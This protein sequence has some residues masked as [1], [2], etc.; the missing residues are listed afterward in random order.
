MKQKMLIISLFLVVG[1]V[2]SSLLAITSLSFTKQIK[3]TF[4]DD[5]NELFED[6]IKLPT[7]EKKVQEDKKSNKLVEWLTKPPTGV[8]KFVEEKKGSDEVLPVLN[9]KEKISPFKDTTQRT[10]LKVAVFYSLL[11]ILVFI[12]IYFLRKRYKKNNNGSSNNQYEVEEDLKKL[13]LLKNKDGNEITPHTKGKGVATPIP[14]HEIR[15][16]LQKWEAGLVAKK[17]KREAETI[18]EWFDRIKGPIEIIHIYEGVRYGEKTCT[19]EE[20]TFI[21]KALKL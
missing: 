18:N 1:L 16:S 7:E 4:N 13:S 6:F 10:N 3:S 20:L 17:M 19:D 21:K 2:I 15:S 12:N 5:N 8:Q 14:I 9:L 11:V